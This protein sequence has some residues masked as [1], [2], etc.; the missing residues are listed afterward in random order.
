M[1]TTLLFAAALLSVATVARAGELTKEECVQAYSRGQDAKDAS[2][3]TLARKLFLSCAQPSCP[4]LVQSDC[5][6]FVD[7]L[8]RLQ[9]T[10][11]FAARDAGGADLPD[12]T[13]YVDDVLV[14]TRLDDGAP[15]DIDPGKHV[16]RFSN[17]GHD[18]TLTVVIETGEKGRAIVA[19]F[20]GGAAAAP[21]PLAAP[22]PALHAHARPKDV[23]THPTGAKLALVTG[24]ALVA[25]GTALA[26]VGFTQLPGGCSLSTSTCGAPPGDP[27]FARASGAAGLIDEGIAA[28]AIGAAVVIGGAIWY[29]HGAH[30]EHE[31]PTVA[32]P[33][34]APGTAGVA[35]S[36][37]F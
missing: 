14:L 9:P 7:D 2:K 19:H 6:R 37:G 35:I 5:A 36:G 31:Q 22:A 30:T 21:A 15:H 17:A 29:A 28:G 13:V 24:A 32:M 25:G 8:G 34:L 18:K 10:V 26:V 23:T 1:K 20:P 16:I 3:L 12:T 27:V 33:W 11:S 4:D